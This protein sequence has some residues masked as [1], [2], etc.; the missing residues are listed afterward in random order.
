MAID[1]KR[2][3]KRYTPQFAKPIYWRFRRFI[4]R[5][6]PPKEI[7]KPEKKS[8]KFQMKLNNKS[9]IFFENSEI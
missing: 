1:L 3:A 7:N 4:A 6:S 8:A 5:H 2:F 9:H